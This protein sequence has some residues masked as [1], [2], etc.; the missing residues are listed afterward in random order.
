MN[1]T[2]RHTIFS[3]ALIVF[4]LA[5][6]APS[7]AAHGVQ[8]TDVIVGLIEHAT[9]KTAMIAGLSGGRFTIPKGSLT[10]V[11]RST[12]PSGRRR[13]ARYRNGD[14]ALQTGRGM[15][16]MDPPQLRIPD[17]RDVDRVWLVMNGRTHRCTD[18]TTAI[19]TA[20]VLAGES[21]PAADRIFLCTVGRSGRTR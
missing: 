6:A 1:T 13:E 9:G 14:G 10:V 4:A 17:L 15:I 11:V 20:A 19:R 18:Q 16:A 5:A 7:D 2:R 3:S 21:P 8:D 12:E